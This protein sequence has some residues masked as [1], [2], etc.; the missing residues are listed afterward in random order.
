MN[1]ARNCYWHCNI[2]KY[3]RLAGKKGVWNT[4]ILIQ[5]FHNPL[6][7]L[8]RISTCNT[9]QCFSPYKA[10]PPHCST[11]HHIS[12]LKRNKMM[13]DYLDKTS[14]QKWQSEYRVWS[15]CKNFASRFSTVYNGCNSYFPDHCRKVI[16][17]I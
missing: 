6:L 13:P 10:L 7:K 17:D 16:F 8:G 5:C 12:P 9:N 14:G 11:C 15:L 4:S 2:W 3:Y 1:Y